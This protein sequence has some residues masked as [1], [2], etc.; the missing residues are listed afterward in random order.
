MSKNIIIVFTRN[1][2][3]GKVKTRLAQTIGNNATLE[4]Y[5]NLLQHT[6]H[7][8]NSLNCDVAVYYSET[9]IQDDIWNKKTYTKY[10]QNGDNL[11][12]RMYNA[13]QQ[14]FNLQYNK[15][16][17]VG[18]D[19]FDLKPQHITQAFK[20][21]EQ[22][23]AVIGPAKDGGYYLLG[24][25]SLIRKVFDNKTWSSDTVLSDTIKDLQ[26]HKIEMLEMLNDIDTF[27]DLKAHPELLKLIKR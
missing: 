5:I 11:G 10:L 1:P 8:L 7:V 26:N 27:E 14:Q 22:H 15:V 24:M 25:T 9:I 12:E 16:V 19:L 4:V 17:I 23:D 20:A 2:E 21:L 18:S 13:F 6:E 3:L